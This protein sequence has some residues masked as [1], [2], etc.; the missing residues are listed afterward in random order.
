MHNLPRTALYPKRYC[1]FCLLFLQS[2]RIRQITRFNK[3][4]YFR[5]CKETSSS[6]IVLI[7]LSDAQ[8]VDGASH[9]GPAS[10]T[11]PSALAARLGTAARGLPSLILTEKKRT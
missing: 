2:G 10:S 1:F 3:M 8:Q 9:S 7:C 6:L 11:R 5:V 4:H